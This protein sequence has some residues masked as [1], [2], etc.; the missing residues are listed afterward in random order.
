MAAALA[1]GSVGDA[2]RAPR[3]APPPLESGLGGPLITKIDWAVMEARNSPEHCGAE[4]ERALRNPARSGRSLPASIR[5]E[6][7]ARVKAAPV[8]FW[9]AP[10]SAHEL[11][12]EAALFQ[13]ELAHTVPAGKVLARLRKA[14]QDRPELARQVL[15]REGYLYSEDPE[16]ATALVDA[17]E[18]DDLFDAPEIEIERGAE[19][20]RAR[21]GE[22]DKYYYATG[23]EAGKRARLIL[24]D[25]V[26]A[27]G[28]R[29]GPA[30][31]ADL[32]TLA[33]QLGFD[34]VRLR[35]WTTD[36]LA[37][38]LRYGDLWI[39]T[40]LAYRGA[41]LER[42]CEAVPSAARE[43]VQ[44]ARELARRRSQVLRVKRRAM[45][46]QIEDSL[47][48]D[49]PK[50]EEGQQ[51]GNLRPAWIWAYTH[52]WDS[53]KFNEDRY[54][55]FD[56][57]GRPRVPQVCVDFII[58][59]LE[60]A[61]GT[62][63]RERGGERARVKGQ[64]DF[65]SLGVGNRRSVGR[66]VEFAEAHA[67]WFDVYR[68]LPDERVPFRQRDRFYQHLSENADRYIPGDIVV[69]HGYRD[70]NELHYHSFFVYEAD[71]VSGMPTLVAANAGRPRIRT[72]ESEMRNAPRRS[73]RMRVRPRLEWLESV[74]PSAVN[75]STVVDT[76]P[77]LKTTG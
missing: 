6:L 28:D 38:D 72:W 50:T 70:D 2:A 5:P 59:T 77:A 14:S 32:R 24:F 47:P 48:F 58:D 65:S 67:A 61:S 22:R 31:H 30:L 9:R 18:L 16:L 3:P 41:K 8:L 10:E 12:V 56:S 75:V 49:E 64:L 42:K 55:V 37:T 54:P 73:I 43:R 23:P 26:W 51:D 60:R 66:F 57:R 1:V 45:L 68:L 63:W 20:F 15:L 39:P 33:D 69:I 52:G 36:E 34:R 53:Y 71:P 62:Y 4:I 40:L 11:P 29:P 27:A 76:P 44:L 17:I 35:H 7:L 46:E 74:L 13:Q 21:R 25:R 19:V